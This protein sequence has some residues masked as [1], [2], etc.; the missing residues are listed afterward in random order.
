MEKDTAVNKY[1]ESSP[2][3]RKTKLFDPKNIEEP[4]FSVILSHATGVASFGPRFHESGLLIRGEMRGESHSPN[5]ASINGDM[6]ALMGQ[7]D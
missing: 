2:F 7:S 1:M 3:Q 4:R 5:A 6:G